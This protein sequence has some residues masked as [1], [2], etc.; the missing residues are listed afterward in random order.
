MPPGG[1]YSFLRKFGSDSHGRWAW[2]HNSWIISDFL[3]L[4]NWSYSYN[5]WPSIKRGKA[6]SHNYISCLHKH[7]FHL[8]ETLH[9]LLIAESAL[10]PLWKVILHSS[11]A[12]CSSEVGMSAAKDTTNALARNAT[13][14]HSLVA[15]R[16]WRIFLHWR[17][18]RSLQILLTLKLGP[19]SH[20]FRILLRAAHAINGIAAYATPGDVESCMMCRPSRI[21]I[22][23]AQQSTQILHQSWIDGLHSWVLMDQRLIQTRFSL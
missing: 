3:I 8:A 18:R 1:I 22:I 11:V 13:L 20:S 6:F 5:L 10:G 17:G 16:L 21:G 12:L 14:T 15:W 7:R 2:G 23:Q 4:E 9:E 19:V